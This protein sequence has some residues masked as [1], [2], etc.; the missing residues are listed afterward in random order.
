LSQ[1]DPEPTDTAH[2]AIEAAVGTYSV[3][4]KVTVNEEVRDVANF[5]LDLFVSFAH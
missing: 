4:A 1:K 5:I 2:E 3:V